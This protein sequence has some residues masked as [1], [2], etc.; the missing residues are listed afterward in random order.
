MRKLPEE[1]GHET[2]IGTIDIKSTPVYFTV[3]RETDST[4]LGTI[5]YEKAILNIGNAFNM[6]TG[7]FIAPKQGVYYFAFTLCTTMNSQA[8][9]M[10]NAIETATLD[11]CTNTDR[12]DA[13]G[14]A[15]LEL[16]SGDVVY[17][18]LTLGNLAYTTH[19]TGYLLQ[20]L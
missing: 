17:T 3:V 2:L 6:Q 5:L 4:T 9:I 11:S 15:T 16:K 14:Q 19:F 10:H 1:T 12:H 13:T 8:K 20:E 7:K 18:D